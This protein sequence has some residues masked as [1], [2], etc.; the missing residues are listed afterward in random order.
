MLVGNTCPLSKTERVGT[1][2]GVTSAPTCFIKNRKRK[3]DYSVKTFLG[4]TPKETE[5]G[6]EIHSLAMPWGK[7][8]SPQEIQFREREATVIPIRPGRNF[9]YFLG[10]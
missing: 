4:S 8:L 10:H 7:D 2:V 9:L 3:L 5:V 1:G 6:W